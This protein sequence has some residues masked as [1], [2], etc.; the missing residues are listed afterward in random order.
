M[1]EER[2][3]EAEP[4]FSDHCFTGDYPRPL[5]DLTIATPRRLALL[6]E[7]D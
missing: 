5:R 4:Q 2:R 6:A 1:G 3:N 7:A